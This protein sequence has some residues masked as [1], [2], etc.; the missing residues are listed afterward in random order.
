MKRYVITD[1]HGGFKALQQVFKMV[2]IDYEND[3]LICI[4]DTCDGWPDVR[5]C[6]EEL[7]KFKK[8]I[9]ILGNHDDWAL[10]FF[11]S[12]KEPMGWFEQG[13]NAT[14]DAFN[15][16]IPEEILSLL[17]NAKLYHVDNDNKIF[18][19]GGFDP[20]FPIDSHHRSSLIWDREL[21]YIANH[22]AAMKKHGHSQKIS[23]YEKIFIGHT[24]TLVF[25]SDKPIKKC[26]LIMLDTGASYSGPLTIM[27]IE[28]EEYWQSDPVESLYPGIKARGHQRKV[29]F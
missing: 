6:F 16:G 19:R 15:K 20:Q 21:P 18:V 13:G 17:K 8:L 11:E 10:E 24:P 12:G 29:K 26:E 2:D 23:T 25:E 5:E 28:T 3:E 7:L 1:I 14:I 4:G 22:K 9:Y 27:D